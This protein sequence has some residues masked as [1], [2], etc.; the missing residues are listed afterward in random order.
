MSK[1]VFVGNLPFNAT[2]DQLRDLFSRHGE[3]ISASIVTDKFTHRSRGFAFV[4]MAGNEAATAAIAALN[5]F[6]LEGRPL[7]VN[8]ARE[9]TQFGRDNRNRNRN[10]RSR[11]KRFHDRPRW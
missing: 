7:T 11:E 9:R 8:E 10:A 1:R 3:V 4:E 6:E 2:E 5:G